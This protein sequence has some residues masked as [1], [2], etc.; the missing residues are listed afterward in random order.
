MRHKNSKKHKGRFQFL[1]II[2]IIANTM[3]STDFNSNCHFDPQLN[4]AINKHITTT[5]STNNGKTLQIREYSNIQ[6][7]QQE[8]SNLKR[9]R[10]IVGAYDN[11]ANIYHMFRITACT[12]STI[13]DWTI[14][15]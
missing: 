4:Q 5:Q 8:M 14:P 6:Q 13:C 10:G 2:K 1:R 7:F 9:P 12:E 15:P 11:D 3:T